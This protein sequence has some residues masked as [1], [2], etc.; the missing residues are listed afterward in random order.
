MNTRSHKSQALLTIGIVLGILVLLNI[1]SIRIFSRL[2]ATKNRIFTLSDASKDLV[3]NLD[4]KVT[5][6][7]YFTEDLPAP[8]NNNRREV[9]DELNEYK[10]YARGNLQYDFIDPSGEKGEMEAQQQ[11]VAPV[12]VQVVKEDKFEVK[13]AYMG[14]VFLYEDKKEI[15]PVIQN[16]ATLEYEI[17]STIKRLTSKGMKKIGFLTGHGEPPLS[18][19][20]RAQELLKKQYELVSVNVSRSTPVPP[21]VTALV[22]MAPT[23]KIPEPEK[24]QIDQYLM[25]GGKIAFLINRVDATLQNRFGRAIDPGLDDMLENCGVHINVDL[26]RDLQCASI[27][28]MQQQYGFSIQSQVPF[29]FLPAASSF[30]KGNAI[31]KDLQGIIFYFVSSIDTVNNAA[32]NLKGEILVRTSKQS[33]R[34][35]GPFML[36]PLQRYTREDVAQSFSEHGIPLAAIVQ[37]QFKSLYAG[38]PVPADTAAGSAPPPQNPLNQSPETRVVLVGDGDFARDQFM[39]NRDN[40]T[41]FANMVDYLADDAGLITIRTKEVSMPPLEQLSDATKKIVKYANL[42]VPPLLVIAYGLFRWRMWRARRKAM[43][44]K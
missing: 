32:R 13:R 15:L 25:R 31:V 19:L 9:L 35:T 4:D 21:D 28:I 40:L 10:A 20:N 1:V 44:M 23:T 2:D 33:G 38:K 11:G 3:R 29:P 6:K 30:S 43:E 12:Q 14:I 42:I 36:D 41:L 16:P 26:V 37:G 17:S 27:S 7:A 22:V 34:L 8:Y 5:I 39:G 18:E 24:F